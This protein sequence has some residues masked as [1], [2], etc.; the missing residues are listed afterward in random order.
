MLEHGGKI[1]AA[2]KQ[3]GIAESDWLDLSTGIN[4]Q[5][6]PVHTVPA[7]V[8]QRLPDGQHNVIE[9]ACRYYGSRNAL[10]VPGSQA[11]IQ[12]LPGLRKP[13][14]VGVISPTYAEHA[15]AWLQRGHEVQLISPADV[16]PVIAQLDV[17][18][19]VNPNNPTGQQYSAETLLNWHQQLQQKAGWLI[20]DEAFMDTQPGNSLAASSHLAGLIILRSLGKFF[21]L[22]GLR[23]GFVL[24]EAELLLK[25]QQQ[26]GPWPVNGPAL[27]IAAQ[28]LQDSLW[29]QQARQRLVCDAAR[30]AGLLAEQGLVVDGGT[31]LFQWL[32]HGE[33]LLIQESLAFKGILTRYF[34]AGVTGIASLRFGLPGNEQHW[35]RLAEALFDLKLAAVYASRG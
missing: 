3:Y 24:A 4:P 21:G 1:S 8:W 31:A 30:L 34:P 2:A 20:V 12:M 26:L 35:Q 14:K 11:A 5:G 27:Y 9:H 29:H 16:E 33:A 13:G 17:L 23:C 22:A 10:V 18:V 28:A 15:Q 25:M 32:Q 6:W 7:E 19:V